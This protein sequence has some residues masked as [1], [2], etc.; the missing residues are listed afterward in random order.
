M[1][2]LLLMQIRRR[3]Q[4]DVTKLPRDWWL[5]IASINMINNKNVCLAKSSSIIS[6]TALLSPILLMEDTLSATFPDILKLVN[7]KTP[8]EWFCQRHHQQKLILRQS[9]KSWKWVGNSCSQSH[10][11]IVCKT[12]RKAVP[13]LEER[14]YS[15]TW[16]NLAWLKGRLNHCLIWVIVHDIYQAQYETG[17][18]KTTLWGISIPITKF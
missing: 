6:I 11:R 17:V 8:S 3:W 16:R 4:R 14:K 15:V 1:W 5:L 9:S 10:Y 7:L 12:P 2:I 18:Y 13:I